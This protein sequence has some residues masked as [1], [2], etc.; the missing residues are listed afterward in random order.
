MSPIERI[1]V[2][3]TVGLLI[4]TA[5]GPAFAAPNDEAPRWS[6]TTAVA[7]VNA[8][9]VT[10]GCPIESPDGQSLMI[11]SM[12]DGGD[13]DIWIAERSGG[14]GAFGAPS[15]LPAPVNSPAQDFCPTPLA[16]GSL[17]F[18]STRP[19]PDAYGNP[20][21]GAG[22]IYITSRVPGSDEW[23][24]P[25]NLGCAPHGPN[26]PSME[27]G[28]SL[29][30]SDDGT[31]LFFSSGAPLGGGS[32][33]IYASAM[34]GEM[35][36]GAPALVAELS[37][38]GYDDVMPNVSRDGKE[39]V[40]ASTRPG[41]ASGFDIYTAA[42]SGSAKGTAGGWSAPINIT[43]VNTAGSETR[44]SLSGDGHRLYLGRDGDIYVSTR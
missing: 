3:A 43:A 32:Q 16:D 25:R 34:I 10:D 24:P 8:A 35:T 2:P 27:Y 38:A 26:M 20:A 11:A 6:P 40:F 23:A 33:D 15:M 1:L 9:G 41:G 5:S 28:P 30:Q 36:F 42:R 18:V 22:D 37:T 44:P 13:N 4:V 29:A 21:C 14:P 39:V 12:R 19:G 31:F 7:Q 17:L